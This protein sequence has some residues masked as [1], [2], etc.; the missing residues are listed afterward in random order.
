MQECSILHTHDTI[1]YIL[2]EAYGSI[3][4]GWSESRGKCLQGQEKSL[5]LVPDLGIDQVAVGVK[6]GRGLE[7]IQE[8]LGLVYEMKVEKN[9]DLAKMVL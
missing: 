5:Q 4:T 6:L 3:Y 7:C 2:I 1:T 9:S 8:K